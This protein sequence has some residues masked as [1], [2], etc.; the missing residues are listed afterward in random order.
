MQLYEDPEGKNITEI[1]AEEPEKASEQSEGPAP[2]PDDFRIES[3]D[4]P[5]EKKEPGAADQPATTNA[6]EAKKTETITEKE[7]IKNP[8]GSEIKKETTIVT[9]QNKS[10]TFARA[11]K[12]ETAILF[13]DMLM[14]RAGGIFTPD[15]PREYWAMTVQDKADLSSLLKESASEEEWKGIPTKWLFIT[16]LA[17]I[18]G[19]KIYHAK[20]PNVTV[21][22]GSVLPGND[23]P[24]GDQKDP[25]KKIENELNQALAVHKQNEMIQE[26]REQNQLLKGLLDKAYNDKKTDPPVMTVLRNEETVSHDI[27]DHYIVNGYD[28]D[29]LQFT[30]KGAIFDPTKANTKGWSPTGVKLGNIS[31]QQKEAFEAWK[32]YKKEK[33]A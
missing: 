6:G 19:G 17:L 4:I 31:Q 23:T 10:S 1:L 18:I 30:D 14:V 15:K 27:A 9:E 3:F 7:T 5:D 33:V 29:V 13:F 26:L 16:I 28:L 2:N 8:D 21:A 22:P 12:A 32:K 24:A 11:F 20:N 25:D